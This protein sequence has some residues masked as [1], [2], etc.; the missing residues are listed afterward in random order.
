MYT[1]W[2]VVFQGNIGHWEHMCLWGAEREEDGKTGRKGITCSAKCTVSDCTSRG[3][4]APAQDRE[5]SWA[6]RHQETEESPILS[7]SKALPLC[8]PESPSEF[9][10]FHSPLIP[11]TVPP[12]VSHRL[13][14]HL[15]IN[16][17]FQKTQCPWTKVKLL[18]HIWLF[19]TPWT[20][21]Y[22]APPSMGFSRQE[23][24]SGLP[25]PSPEELP[26]P[27]IEPGSPSL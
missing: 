22:H 12:V 20:T 17:I 19:A 6:T 11:I 1:S 15:N 23:Y 26:D 18:G 14:T 10:H 7:A 3:G 5:H 13:S 4:A 8:T 24:W 2:G 25:F 9:L 16:F 21:A 27:G